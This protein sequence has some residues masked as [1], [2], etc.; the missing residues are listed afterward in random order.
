MEQL[1][2]IHNTITH[3]IDKTDL[4]ADIILGIKIFIVGYFLTLLDVFKFGWN[5]KTIILILF[6]ASSAAS[7][8]FLLKIIYPKLST[9]EPTSLIYFKHLSAKFKNNKKQGVDDL[10]KLSEENFNKDLSNQIISLS[11]VAECKYFDLRKSIGALFLEV[12]LL[13]FFKIL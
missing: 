8:F 2:F 5:W 11:I 10:N 7:F 4:K 13:I 9:E 6:I 1:K 12:I 3:W